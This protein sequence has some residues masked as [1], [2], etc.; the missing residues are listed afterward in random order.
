V[1]KGFKN[2]KKGKTLHG[3]KEKS[4]ETYGKLER[5]GPGVEISFGRNEEGEEAGD[6]DP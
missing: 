1:G 5:E 3:R 6:K 2:Q 4:S